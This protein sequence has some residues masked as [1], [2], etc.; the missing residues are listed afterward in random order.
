M[1]NQIPFMQSDLM[2]AS[3]SGPIFPAKI[4]PEEMKWK[5]LKWLIK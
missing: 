2:N 1:D 5:L 4:F 3:Q